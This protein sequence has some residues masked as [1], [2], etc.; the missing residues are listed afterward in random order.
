[1]Q[2]S[3]ELKYNLLYTGN[4]DDYKKSEA[5]HAWNL[6]MD[7]YT[8]ATISKSNN[9]IFE[10]TKKLIELKGKYYI[11][12]SFINLIETK[13]RV[14]LVNVVCDFGDKYKLHGFEDEVKQLNI[15]GGYKID[16]NNIE[17]EI[18]RVSKQVK[19]FETQIKIVEEKIE[20]LKKGS[21]K[22]SIAKTIW[23]AAQHQSYPFEKDAV[24]NDLVLCIND[25][26]ETNELIKANERR[27]KNG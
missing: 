1:M 20:K 23:K 6:I 22:T 7:E 16:I 5:V 9:I 18:I 12:S 24:V 27:K 13:I 25:I 2:L 15:L 8:E 4:P 21:S 11:V 17:N 3:D 26:I 19:N 14:N 10:E